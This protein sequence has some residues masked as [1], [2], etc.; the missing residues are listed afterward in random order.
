LQTNQVAAG[1]GV[2]I[3]DFGATNAASRFYRARAVQ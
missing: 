2:E 3:S 1:S